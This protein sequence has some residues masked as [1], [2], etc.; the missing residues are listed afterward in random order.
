MLKPN[1]DQL[2][3]QS[4]DLFMQMDLDGDGMITKNEFLQHVLK[5]R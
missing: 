5:S 2:E 4:R 3:A 1:K